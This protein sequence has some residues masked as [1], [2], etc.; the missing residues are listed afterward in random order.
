MGTV[1]P[2]FVLITT[3]ISEINLCGKFI[4]ALFM[5]MEEKDRINV[6]PDLDVTLYVV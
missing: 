6:V 3:L 2:V 5:T 4:Q 1:I